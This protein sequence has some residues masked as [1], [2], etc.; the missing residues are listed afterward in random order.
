MN[1]LQI[2]PYSYLSGTSRHLFLLSRGLQK[3]GHQVTLVCPPS[4]WLPEQACKAGITVMERGMNGRRSWETIRDLVRTIGANNVDVIHT[5]ATRAAYH[6]WPVAWLTRRPLVATAHTLTSDPIYRRIVPYGRNRVIAVSE[7]I[8]QSLLARGA[9][10]ARVQT[11]YNGTE[12]FATEPETEKEPSVRE[13]LGLPLDALIVGV[14][15]HISDLKGQPL[16]VRALPSIIA[17]CP[18][19][20]FVLVG[21]ATPPVREGLLRDAGALGVADRL[22]LTGMRY[23]TPRLM[24]A[25]D[26][27]AAPSTMEALSMVSL[28]AMAIGKAVVGTR[29]GGIPE[30][31]QED[32]TGLL[33]EREPAALAQAIVALLQDPA[34]REAMGR[35]GRARVQAYFSV[36]VMAATVEALYREIQA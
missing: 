35:A 17:R 8:R 4:G 11:V 31:I 5:H 10:P 36:D 14:F 9:P 15:G 6:G 28:E 26:M 29:V 34:R 16:L 21:H 2:I 12:I 1:I 23:D 24:A 19:A 22:R 3:R 33:V 27:V 20:Y 7:F 13:E 18:N 25:M 32:V 30:V